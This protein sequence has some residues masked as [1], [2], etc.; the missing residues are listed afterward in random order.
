MQV[1][2]SPAKASSA[3]NPVRLFAVDLNGTLL[4]NPEATARFTAAWNQQREETRPHLVYSCGR[5]LEEI[6]VLVEQHN[7]PQPTALIGGLGTSVKLPGRDGEAATFNARFAAG[8]SFARV[9]EL[10]GKIGGLWRDVPTFLHPYK[11]EWRWRN[12]GPAQL[13]QL[14]SRLAEAGIEGTVH[15]TDN[16]YVEVVPARASKGTALDYLCSLLSVPMDAVLVAGD[17]L[18]DASMMVLPNVKRIVIDNSLPEL[19]A[20]LVGCD[21]YFSSRIMA[22]GVL[23]GLRHFGVLSGR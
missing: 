22:D 9:D 17:T 8:W 11:S 5:S 6:A 19:L 14:K 18:H 15:Y 12:A 20:E 23:D 16:R 2:S 21:K 1:L 7:L 13:Q 10:L 3:A 4:G